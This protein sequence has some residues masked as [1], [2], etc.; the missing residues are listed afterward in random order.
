MTGSV[1]PKGAIQKSIVALLGVLIALFGGAGVWF[2]LSTTEPWSTSQIPTLLLFGGL[3][4]T[5]MG[6]LAFAIRP[7]VAGF[8]LLNVSLCGTVW[9][10]ATA[11][12]AVRDSG[13]LAQVSLDEWLRMAAGTLLIA[14]FA[15]LAIRAR[16]R[17]RPAIPSP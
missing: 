16:R 11:Y 1:L 7:S 4:V 8:W 17:A 14:G 5:G 12:L 13:G 9:L 10:N 6:L 3:T 15:F 2:S